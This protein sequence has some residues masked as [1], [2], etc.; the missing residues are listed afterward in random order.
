LAYGFWAAKSVVFVAFGFL[1][2]SFIV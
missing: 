1:A 2:R